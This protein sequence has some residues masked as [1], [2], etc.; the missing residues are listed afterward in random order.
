MLTIHK[1]LKESF[2]FI[3]NITFNAYV[4]RIVDGDT[5]VLENGQRVRL[6]GIDC[7]ETNHPVK[8]KEPHG[9]EAT[10]FTRYFIEGKKIKLELDIELHD[11][12]NRLLAYV[13]VDDIFLNDTL[14][15]TGMA[16]I[17]TFPPNVKYV[18]RFLESQD[19]ARNQKTGIWADFNLN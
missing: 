11:R 7:P 12:Y 15:L 8:G 10:E 4:T 18:D 6:I 13:Y 1:Y 16:Q 2:E 17:T 14:L 3:P 9:K 5:F 19:K